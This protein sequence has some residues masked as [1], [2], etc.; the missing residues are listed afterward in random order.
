MFFGNLMLGSCL[1]VYTGLR[2][3]FLKQRGLLM[4]LIL[5][6]IGFSI[7]CFVNCRAVQNNELNLDSNQL[8]TIKVQPDQIKMRPDYY[9]G[10]ATL[11]NEKQQVLFSG[12]IRPDSPLQAGN[13]F[14]KPLLLVVRAEVKPIEASTNQNQFNA[15][16]YYATQSITNS[17][18]IKS[19]VNL[20]ESHH[21]NLVD[22]IHSFRMGLINYANQ[23]PKPLNIYVLSL[24]IGE[25]TDEAY[26]EIT[27][28]KQ[29]GLIHLFSIS[30]LHV[31]YFISIIER[32]FIYLRMRREHYQILIILILPLYFI[33]SGSSVGLLRAILM[34]EAGMLARTFKLRVRGIDIWSIALIINLILA[35]RTLIQFGSQ[36]SYAL[37]FG[38]IFTNKLGFIK[39]TMLMNVIGIPF[40]I[41]HVYEWHFLTFLANLLILPLFSILIF[42]MVIVGMISFTVIPLISVLIA[43]FLTIFDGTINWFG[44][45]PGN[46]LFGRPPVL[47]ATGL[48]IMT[49]LLVDKPKIR[50]WLI[51]F[52]MYLITFM[53]IH[54]PVNGEVTYFDVGQGDSFLIRTPFNRSVN[55]IDTGGRV[56]FGKN[57][58]QTKF[59]A[60]KTSIN[61]LKSIGINRIDNLF[62]THQ[63]ADHSGDLPAF[64]TQM[65]V[66]N[67]IIPEGMQNN[68]NFMA[69]ISGK[70]NHTNLLLAKSG[71]RFSNRQI[72]IYH[73][74]EPGIGANED[75]LVIGTTINKLN[76]LFTGDLDQAG[77]RA[78]IKQYPHLKAS[79]LKVGHHG[80]KTST[81]PELLD[82]LHPQIAIISAGRN[83]RYG[84]P[85]SDV[86]NELNRRQ[87][88]V[89]NTQTNGMI[90][91]RYGMFNSAHFKTYM[92]R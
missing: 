78:V 51:L 58:V 79:V 7:V 2:I 11:L 21:L 17:V 89:Y 22:M 90:A 66:V 65:R 46:I 59:N 1:L 5:C 14:T 8:I 55:L 69:K 37:S 19:I 73:P 3:L 41:F 84:H 4:V 13:D 9:Y 10:K 18:K 88:K 31:Y 33:F 83:N 70:M 61:Y 91:Y 74:V 35:P 54:F 43:N 62:I 45:L 77:E 81:A 75:S 48:F 63:D 80:S 6:G 20:S 36:L 29:L 23:L 27:G 34:V 67:L 26:D 32:I 16:Q 53:L 71:M 47:V 86:M 49:L 40:I 52:G 12:S 28:I 76:W 44:A 39:Q 64:L 56:L 30:G 87:I 68:Q 15:K 82:Q 38:L 50:R 57:Q 85:N 72:N 24:I 60:E 25:M 92:S 42:P